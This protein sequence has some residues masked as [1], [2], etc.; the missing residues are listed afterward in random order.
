MNFKRR[1]FFKIA[2]ASAVSATAASLVIGQAARV[3]AMP[4]VPPFPA[5]LPADDEFVPARV[6]AAAVP[7]Y[8]SLDPNNR[9][10]IRSVPRDK[11]IEVSGEVDGPGPER[12][13]TWYKTRDGFAYS[14]WLQ[15]MEPYR[16]PKVYTSLGDWGIWIETIVANAPAYA[17][18]DESS[19]LD[20][21]YNYGTVFHATEA[22]IDALGRV[23]YNTN[24]EYTSKDDNI[25]PTNHW[26]PA[27]LTRKVEEDTWSAINPHTPDKRIEIDLGQQTVTCFEG[28]KAV[29]G[30]RCASGASFKIGDEEVDFSTP[31]GEFSAI[32]KM[33]SRHMRAPEAERDSSA[34]FDLPGVPWS[35]FFT[36]DGIAIHGTYWH[37]D[38]G[39][40]RSHGCVN[41]PIS[42]AK[43]I[44]FWTNPVAPYQDDFVQGDV[45]EVK[46][47]QIVV[48]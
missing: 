11:T 3:S 1:D 8:T 22:H 46:A 21:I 17:K 48:A 14:A 37:N 38:Y 5:P 45:K 25:S 24:D 19:R 42:V 28:D 4:I 13:R 10:L 6:L 44:Y 34:W 27:V 12:N 31:R 20:Y 47:T 43:W 18:P 9:K 2:A 16:T 35:T 40:P 29:L 33:P 7:V 41:V 23:W 26:V 36:Y 30:S 15:K 32:L 39:V